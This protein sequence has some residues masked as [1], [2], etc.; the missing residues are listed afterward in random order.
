VATNGGIVNIR[1]GPGTNYSIVIKLSNG[2]RL[3]VLDQNADGTWL[4]VRFEGGEGW[5]STALTRVNDAS[6]MTKQ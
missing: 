4:K 2:T 3:E 5:I 6:T 1:S